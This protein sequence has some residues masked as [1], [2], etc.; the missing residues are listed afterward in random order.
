V[1][2]GPRSASAGAE[3]RA[4]LRQPAPH[5]TWFRVDEALELTPVEEDAAHWCI[6]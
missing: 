1:T 6:N 5:E 4:L 3:G 2:P